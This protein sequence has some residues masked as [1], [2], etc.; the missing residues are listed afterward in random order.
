[1][2]DKFKLCSRLKPSEICL[3]VQQYR[4]GVTSQKYHEHIPKHRISTDQ[5]VNLLRALVVHFSRMGPELIV[6]SYLN[7]RGRIPTAEPGLH[8]VVAF[9]EPGVKRMYCG[10]NIMAWSDQVIVPAEF[11][12]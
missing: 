4:E 3:V 2:Y 1:M 8:I 7:S 11:R 5:L 10:S 6:S 9:N 12:R